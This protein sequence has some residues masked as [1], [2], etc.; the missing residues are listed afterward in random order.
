MKSFLRNNNLNLTRL[1]LSSMVILGHSYALAP[2]DGGKDIILQ[3]TGFTYSGALAVKMFFFISGLLVC[4]SII[5]NPN[6][7]SYII[8]RFF[9]IIPA[10][11][12]MLL[13]TCFLVGPIVTSFSFFDYLLNNQV[14]TYLSVNLNL[15]SPA[16]YNLPGVFANNF[17]QNSVNGSLWT[18]SYEVEMYTYLLAFSMLG[19][20]KYRRFASAIF[21]FIIALPTLNLP[22]YHEIYSSNPEIYYLPMSFSFGCMFALWREE[23]QINIKFFI[24]LLLMTTL[25]KQY[26]IY[27]TLFYFCC[28]YFSLL[29]SDSRNIK[30]PALKLDISYGVY[31]YGF[32]VQQLINHIFPDEGFLFN[33]IVSLSICYPIA[34]LSYIYIEKPSIDFGRRIKN[35]PSDFVNNTRYYLLS[36]PRTKK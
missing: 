33:T 16:Y 32:L 27:T 4:N 22:W 11:L 13:I 19:L 36:F 29:I 10:L 1:I 9:R 14:L 12:V 21:I 6:P 5:S 34:Y 23:I 18:L 3:L 31:I 20:L 15:F 26:T 25:M 35:S 24:G 8:S 7:V 2:S 30:I 28:F 17:Y